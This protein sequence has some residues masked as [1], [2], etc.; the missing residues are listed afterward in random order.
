MKKPS[1]IYQKQP[2]YQLMLE[3]VKEQISSQNPNRPTNQDF[4][5]FE[6]TSVL[7]MVLGI[8]KEEV[9]GDYLLSFKK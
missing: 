9:M 6:I 8:S 4:N 3:N 5:I 1:Y 7:G 2:L